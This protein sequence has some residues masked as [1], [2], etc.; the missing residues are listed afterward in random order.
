MA[1][2]SVLIIGAGTKGAISEVS[3]AKA[4]STAP[5]HIVGFVDPDTGKAKTAAENW[6]CEAFA[7]IA[8]AFDRLGSVDVVTVATPDATHEAVL[9]QLVGKPCKLIFAEKPFTQRA[10]DARELLQSFSA[11]G[12]AVMVNYTRRFAPGFQKLA[13]Q[14]Q[15]GELGEFLGGSGFYGKGLYHNGSH[16]IDLLRMLFDEVEPGQVIGE[17]DDGNPSDP[18]VSALLEVK[19]KPFYLGV[20]PRTAVNAF[21]AVL[22]FSKA[23]IIITDVG[24]CVISR[25]IELRSDFP[26]ENVYG[27]RYSIEWPKVFEPLPMEA[28]TQNIAD[29]LINGTPLLSPAENAVRVLEICEALS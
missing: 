10:G 12:Q 21:E 26:T 19:H 27:Q 24:E 7:D 20:I 3:H 22:Y 28:A 29:H 25:F 9:R 8:T 6:D 1:E 23:Q 4:F 16:M 2:Y 14:I 5:F 17:V 15:D 18:S 13:S 11:F